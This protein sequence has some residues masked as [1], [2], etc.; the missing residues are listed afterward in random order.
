MESGSSNQPKGIL[1]YSISSVAGGTSGA[2]CD[3]ADFIDLK[4]EVL[5]DNVDIESCAFL[6]N[7]KVESANRYK[8]SPS[9]VR[10]WSIAP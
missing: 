4:K 9:T 1:N 7:T 10:R 5:V 2:A 3:F 6:T 8:V